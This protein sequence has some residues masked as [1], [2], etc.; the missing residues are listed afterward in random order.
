MEKEQFITL[1][2][3]EQEALRRFLL[4]LCCGNKDEAD[5]IAQEAFIKAYL[6]ISKFHDEN[7]FNSWLYKIAYNTFIDHVRSK[8]MLTPLNDA[9]HEISESTADNA[10]NYQELYNALDTLSPKERSAILLYYLKGYAIKEIG[11]ITDCSEDAVKAQLSRGR[12]QLKT[13]IT[14]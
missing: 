13:K 7:K 9:S 10:F 6:T 8:R 2:Q 14:Q 11:K 4:A 12:K 1:V 5:D 3:R